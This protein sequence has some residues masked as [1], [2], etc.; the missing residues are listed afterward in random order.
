V[1]V[2]TTDDDAA[3][4][5]HRALREQ[6]LIR[7][8]VTF[9]NH[10]SY[11][12]CPRPV[13]ERYQE[14]QRELEAQPVEFLGRRLRDLLADARAALAAHLGADADEV[15][16]EPNVTTALN[17]VA[18]S[19]P[20]EAG[21]EIL[22]ADHEYGALERCWTF[23]CEKRGSKIVTQRLPTPLADPAAVVEAVWAGVTPRTRVLFLSHVTSPSAAI[24]PI[25]PLIARARERGI[26]TVIDGAHAPGQLE[27]DLHALG[28][29]FYGGNCH[30]W[31]CAP[32]GAGFLYARR[33]VQPLLEP[34]IVSWGWRPRDPG[35]SKFVDEQ[36]RQATRDVSAYLAV[37]DA[38]EFQR[39]NDWAQVRAE[40]HALARLAREDVR[41]LTGLPD[42]VADSPDWY[43]QMATMPLG[44]VDA[45]EL[46]RRLYEDDGIEIPVSRSGDQTRVRIS[47][48]GYNT[49]AD[50]EKLVSALARLLPRLSPV[51]A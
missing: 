26:W 28:V 7:P 5:R 24:L 43:A 18:R 49:R 48:Q 8:G 51:N 50:V 33:E 9:L 31:L 32:K 46:K 36:E 37:P 23:V 14:W 40:C 19:L 4:A 2:Q 45:A 25:A 35:P 29:D 30:K 15:V 3:E 11:G 21:D 38:I 1:Q 17:V 44:D 41:K 34:L 13:F 22:T 27:L 10:G 12:A 16:Y 42:L 6:F 47:V 20:L 39:A